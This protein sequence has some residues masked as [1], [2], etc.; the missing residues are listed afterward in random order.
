MRDTNL[1]RRGRAAF[2]AE[3]GSGV[4]AELATGRVV[5]RVVKAVGAAVLKK[6]VVRRIDVRHDLGEDLLRILEIY[7]RVNNNN[8]LNCL[9]LPQRPDGAGRL[10]S[11]ERLMLV[12]R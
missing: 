9:Q 11:L 8:H 1:S 6:N 4:Q 2:L 3:L 12:D 5:G 10:A 7:S